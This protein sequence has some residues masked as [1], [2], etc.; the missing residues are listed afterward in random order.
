MTEEKQYCEDCIKYYTC[1]QSVTKP[2]TTC[3]NY[4]WNQKTLKNITAE[5]T[6]EISPQSPA[7]DISSRKFDTGATRDNV[8]GKLDYMKALSPIVLRRYVQYLD[9]HRTMPDGSLRE[10][11]NWKQGIPL[12]V[13]HSSNGRHFFAA[14]LLEEGYEVSDNHGPVNEEDAL[15][16]ELFNTM[17][18]LHELL[19]AKL[20]PVED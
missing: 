19:K 4:K 20:T 16:G 17:G 3:S 2:A 13:Y 18:R 12:D 6:P 5:D 9:K 15:C 7:G 10:F 14:W 8:E 11:D 1:V